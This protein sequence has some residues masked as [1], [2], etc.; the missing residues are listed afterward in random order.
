[1]HE[2]V[3]RVKTIGGKL[4]KVRQT[5][6]FFYLSNASTSHLLVARELHALRALL[7]LQPETVCS[8]AM[9][10][11]SCSRIALQ[12]SKSSLW[13]WGKIRRIKWQ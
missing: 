8:N 7:K 4:L 12:F 11:K 10:S 1:M 6:C 3:H 2:Q 9:P 13:V 5:D